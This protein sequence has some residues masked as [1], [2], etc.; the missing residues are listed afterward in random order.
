MVKRSSVWKTV[1]KAAVIALIV[2]VGIAL[3][4]KFIY[5][6]VGRG[7]LVRVAHA[8]DERYLRCLKEQSIPFRIQGESVMVDFTWLSRAEEGC[9]AK[10]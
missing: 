5:S 7:E 9:Q 8:N 3:A 6:Q 1:N 10:P 2:L 4:V